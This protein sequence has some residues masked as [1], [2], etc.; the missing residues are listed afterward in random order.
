MSNT[1]EDF[2]NT[3]AELSLG[4]TGSLIM[5]RCE[6]YGMARGC[7]TGCPVLRA[8]EC[9]L[10]DSENKELYEQVIEEGLHD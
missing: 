1:R 5:S 9:K 7:D 4:G 10:K 3:L 2:S 6:S 8:G